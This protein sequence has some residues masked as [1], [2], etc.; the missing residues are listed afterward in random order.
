VSGNFSPFSA[1]LQ[2]SHIRI[3]LLRANQNVCPKDY[4][5]LG[6]YLP[7]TAKAADQNDINGRNVSCLLNACRLN[8]L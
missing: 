2:R 7:H 6:V 3:P 1:A 5:G 4:G 8:R